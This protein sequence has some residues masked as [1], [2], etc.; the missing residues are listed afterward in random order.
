MTFNFIDCL[1]ACLCAW[2]LARL[3]PCFAWLVARSL[4]CVLCWLLIFEFFRA[5]FICFLNS[6]IIPEFAH[7][8]RSIFR[9][10]NFPKKRRK[11]NLKF[12]RDLSLRIGNYLRLWRKPGFTTLFIVFLGRTYNWKVGR[13]GCPSHWLD[14]Q[15]RQSTPWPIT[16]IILLVLCLRGVVLLYLL[17]T[18]VL[19]SIFMTV[20]WSYY[21]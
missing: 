1:L 7:V 6:L 21:M 19:F 8:L 18:R 16:A 5:S 2:L 11:Q 13:N 9:I 4:A 17:P 12:L 10:C 3:P 14:W 15:W 20:T